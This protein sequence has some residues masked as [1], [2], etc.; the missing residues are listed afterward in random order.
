MAEI[1]IPGRYAPGLLKLTQLRREEVNELAAGLASAEQALSVER[2]LSSL[3]GRIPSIPRDDLRMVLDSLRSLYLFRAK[4][5]LTVD[6]CVQAVSD[7]VERG[8]ASELSF[9]NKSRADFERDLTSL[10]SVESLAVE[11]KGL[12]L[13]VEQP[14]VFHGARVLTDLR[15]VFGSDIQQLPSAALIVHTLRITYHEDDTLREFYVA[16]DSEEVENLSRIL[17]RAK[18]K[19]QGLEQLLQAADVPR[20]DFRLSFGRSD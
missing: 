14:H 8:S 5:D 18:M 12:D 7:A 4:E 2:L 6:E 11:A 9:D 17:E 1:T 20:L 15:P 10:L 3:G 13:L 19:E 16:L